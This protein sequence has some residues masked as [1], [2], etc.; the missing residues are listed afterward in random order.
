LARQTLLRKKSAS[1]TA[2][3]LKQ[4]IDNQ[5]QEIE[6]LKTNLTVVQ[7][8]FSCAKS[9]KQILINKIKIAQ[10]KQ[11]LQS[12]ISNM[13][14]SSALSAFERME[15]KVLSL[16]AE[17]QS[18]YELGGTDLEAQ[19]AAL[20][21]GSDVDDEL[22][23]MKAQL[24]GSSVNTE[25]LPSITTSQPVLDKPVSPVDAELE[26]LRKQLDQM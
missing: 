20:V 24:T 13:G 6:K 4:H 18:A 11:K 12:N 16:E 7:N 25:D 3:T 17:S 8:K 5:S 22:A 14:T 23:M 9:Q 1:E 26:A 2:K 10:N 19:F 15:E 21:A